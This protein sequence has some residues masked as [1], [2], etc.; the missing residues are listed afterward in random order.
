VFDLLHPGIG[1]VRRR[2][3]RR[4]AH[5][6][7]TQSFRIARELHRRGVG[8]ALALARDPGLQDAARPEADLADDRNADASIATAAPGGGT[9][10]QARY[11]PAIAV[12]SATPGPSGLIDERMS[13]LRMWLNSWAMTPCN[14][15][16]FSRSRAPRVTAMAALAGGAPARR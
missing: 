9:A 16:R 3:L 11:R 8:Q 1:D 10:P 6:R 7:V 4:D 13:P 2:A 14:C 5:Q 15:S 12:P